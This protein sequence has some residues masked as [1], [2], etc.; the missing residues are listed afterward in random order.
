MSAR[1]RR[2][3][4]SSMTEFSASMVIFILFVFCPLINVGIL[5]VRYL[6]AHGIITEMTHRISV[7]E[8]RSDAYNYLKGN[9][10]WTSFLSKCGVSVS[11][12]KLTMIVCGKDVG[13]KTKFSN[14]AEISPDWLPNGTKGPCVYSVQLTAD[15][16]LS[17]LFNAQAGLPGFTKPVTISINSQAQWESL[18]RDPQTSAY[19]LNE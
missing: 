16:A 6:I 19:Y 5:P 3:T 1:R 7:C 13:D 15:C 10:W 2:Q 18:G 17:P 12:P 8:K 11:N 14:S 9:Q 4:G